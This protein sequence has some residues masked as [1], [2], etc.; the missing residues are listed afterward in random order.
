MHARIRV[1]WFRTQKGRSVFNQHC[2]TPTDIFNYLQSY[3]SWTKNN[4]PAITDRRRCGSVW[5]WVWVFV[6]GQRAPLLGPHVSAEQTWSP[7]RG[8]S[9]RTPPLPQTSTQPPLHLALCFAWSH[10][11]G[12]EQT[13]H[14]IIMGTV[15]HPPSLGLEAYPKILGSLLA[16]FVSHHGQQIF[17]KPSV[18][19]FVPVIV[20][21]WKYCTI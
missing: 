5:V 8:I 12:E 18:L 2:K 6:V 1:S 10:A 15:V 9:V 19:P 4:P 13:Q 14:A 7:G 16:L 20:T 21:S 11:T 17:L 3:S